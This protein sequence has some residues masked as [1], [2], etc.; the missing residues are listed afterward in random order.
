MYI[1]S[2]NERGLLVLLDD[3]I[4]GALDEFREGFATSIRVRLDANGRMTVSDDSNGVDPTL[5]LPMGQI[6]LEAML[7][8]VRAERPINGVLAK[9]SPHG[10]AYCVINALSRECVVESC[11][12]HQTARLIFAQGR[13][14]EP[15]AIAESHLPNGFTVSFLPDPEIFGD[16]KLSPTIVRKF[17]WEQAVLSPG[18]RIVFHDES[19][20]FSETFRFPDGVLE[21]VKRESADEQPIWPAPVRFECRLG[22]HRLDIAAHL[23]NRSAPRH[24]AFANRS[25]CSQGGTHVNA[26]YAG[27]AKALQRCAPL[28]MKGI[29]GWGTWDFVR[30]VVL[31]IAVDIEDAHYEGPVRE[32]LANP[33]ID[34]WVTTFVSTSF[35]EFFLTHFDYIR[36]WQAALEAA[37]VVPRE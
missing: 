3:V 33:E 9:G 10:L 26:A 21:F 7:T 23:V 35:E 5:C 36:R 11:R 13:A 1:G 32:K 34:R 12:D 22:R 15:L 16:A 4:E 6:A 30:G 31:A 18:V 14:V 24:T 20:A 17:L 27:I 2:T 28:S 29:E 25:P 8:D 19:A 37:D